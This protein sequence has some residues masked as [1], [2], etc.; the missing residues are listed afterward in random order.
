MGDVQYTLFKA[1]VKGD[2]NEDFVAIYENEMLWFKTPDA[3]NS[4]V[5]IAAR[6]GQ[7]EVVKK[8][9]SLFPVLLRQKNNLD[10]TP[11]H[12]AAAFGTE[13]TVQLLISLLQN[14]SSSTTPV[15]HLLEVN[16]DGDTP[17]HVAFRYRNMAI[18]QELFS[19]V[20]KDHPEILVMKTNLH[21]E[22]PLHLYVRCCPDDDFLTN[23]EVINEGSSEISNKQALVFKLV[24]AN[25]FC[26]FELDSEGF[27]PL[28]R[29]AQ[30]GRVL[31]LYGLFLKHPLSMECRDSKGKSFLDHLSLRMT[32]KAQD[33]KDNTMYVCKKILQLQ[34]VDD[35]LTCSRDQDG[36]TPLHWAILNKDFDLASLILERHAAAHSSARKELLISVKNLQ[37][38]TVHDFITSKP[39]IPQVLKNLLEEATRGIIMN[40]QLYNT[41]KNLDVGVFIQQANDDDDDDD[42]DDFFSRQDVD[43][44]NILHIPLHLQSAYNFTAGNL[45]SYRRFFKEAIKRCPKLMYQR[46]CNGDTPLHIAARTTFLEADSLW[47]I[48]FRTWNGMK[49]DDEWLA[50]HQI[51]PWRMKYSRGH[52]PIH[53]SARN[54]N[55]GVFHANIK[56]LNSRYRTEAVE[57]LLDVNDHGETAYHLIARYAEPQLDTGY[58]FNPDSKTAAYKRDLEGL[59]PVIR[60]AHYGRSILVRKF[61]EWCP[62]SINMMDYK[63]RNVLH[64]LCTSPSTKVDE[65][66]NLLQHWESNR[67]QYPE[68]ILLVLSKDEDGNT[69][70]HLAVLHQNFKV[71]DSLFTHFDVGDR[72]YTKHLMDLNNNQGESFKDLITCGSGIPPN[73]KELIQQADTRHLLTTMDDH[74][75]EAAT[76][77]DVDYIERESGSSVLLSQSNDG[78]NVLHLAL[79]HHQLPLIEFLLNDDMYFRLIYG[80][81]YKGDTPLHLAVS[82]QTDEPSTLTFLQ[83]CLHRWKTSPSF[84]SK[85]Y[86]APWTVRNSKGN[87]YL[88]EAARV[89]SYKVIFSDFLIDKDIK[90]VNDHGETVFHVMV[91]YATETAKNYLE[92]LTKQMQSLVYIQDS[93]GFTPVLRALQ[94]GRLGMAMLLIQQ[95]PRSVEIPDNK[96][97]TVLHHLRAL[98]VDLVDQVKDILPVWN[99]FF[100][101]PGVDELRI[102]QNEDGNTPLH[103]AIIEGDF[104]KSKFLME[105][106]LQSENR[107][108]LI[109]VNN[110]GHLVFE[111]VSSQAHILAMKELQ[112][113]VSR[114]YVK[115]TNL[116]D[117]AMDDEL[118]RAA[119][120]GNI[121]IFDSMIVDDVTVVNDT[122]SR[123][124]NLPEAYF[125]SQTPG[126]SNIIHIALRHG[127][128]NKRVE[129]FIFIEIALER[130]P[131]LSMQSENKGDTPLHLAVKWKSG[132]SIVKLL[133]KASQN[134]LLDESKKAFYV[135]PW[136]MKNYKGCFPIHEALQSGNL[137]AAE[138]LFDCDTEANIRVSN[139]GDTAL[140]SFAKN[141]LPIGC[142]SY[143]QVSSTISIPPRPQWSD[144]FAPL[145]IYR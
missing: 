78:S 61:S 53:E 20:I 71:A 52:M 72:S 55:L 90:D 45:G 12:E 141:G 128:E 134:F 8:A 63:G 92:N 5:H 122:E 88:H 62:K 144:I 99:E 60:A 127:K 67:T 64:H 26:I 83:L 103:L 29:A 42:D 80:N 91:K 33:S 85:N 30:Y 129:K 109:I 38:S 142:T 39:G 145:A 118:Y 19:Y 25:F 105:K 31:F 120:E 119:I 56:H 104:T 86:P 117:K 47:T 113:M 70:L 22:T 102:A 1:A 4:I 121:K 115:E 124:P 81:D 35:I 136:A 7:L 126:G 14:N 79:R 93:E 112:S 95:C 43:G 125:C 135:A 75:Y 3:G 89:C 54:Q 133:I 106:C 74:L 96:G 50:D 131:I 101:R 27:N 143:T 65:L 130:Y 87:T 11:L 68:S 111:L 37:G 132:L 69:P 94:Y 2:M 57:A 123:P 66:E 34:P 114:S 21:K 18:A 58:I 9:V 138:A 17:F 6:H 97:R 32:N 24:E 51:P 13:E 10:N 36:N 98:V 15:S 84:K 76:K 140:H 107:R 108:E 110:D 40:E 46:D 139:L 48:S 73:L 116:I 82:L 44:K 41:A 49:E 77:G 23:K 28:M 59:T 137:K 16:H 100:K